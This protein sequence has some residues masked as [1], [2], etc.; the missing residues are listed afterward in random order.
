MENLHKDQILRYRGHLSDSEHFS[1]NSVSSGHNSQS[2]AQIY[3]LELSVKAAF[4][5]LKQND[6]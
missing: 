2:V 5:V 6:T 1:R 3:R 4:F